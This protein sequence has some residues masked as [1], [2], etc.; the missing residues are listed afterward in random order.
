MESRFDFDF[1]RVRIHIDE[2]AAESANSVNALA[3]TTGNDIVFAK[4]WY[5]PNTLEGQKLLAHELTHVIQQTSA[6]PL[7]ADSS[8][9]P[10]GAASP[11]ANGLHQPQP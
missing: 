10:V 11:A 6:P 9:V 2:S 5:R 4:E 3:Y 8:R 1:S 7:A